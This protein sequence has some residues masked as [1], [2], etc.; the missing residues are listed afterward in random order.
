MSSGAWEILEGLPAYGAPAVPF[1]AT[2]LGAHREGLVAKFKTSAGDWIGNFQRGMTS[3]DQMCQHPDGRHVVVVAGGTAY[4]VDPET[5]VLANHFDAQI[6][7][8]I[9]FPV[10]GLILFSNGLWFDALDVRGSAWR[11]RR[12]SWDGFRKV[13]LEGNVIRG[14]A[15]APDGADGT[16]HPFAVDVR[17]GE[18]TGGSYDGPPM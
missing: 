8:V 11:S 6:E 9:S 10:E 15:Y 12:I 5:Q 14:E 1:S 13:S 3:C 2:G 16:W 4:V 17:T 7:Q 18:V